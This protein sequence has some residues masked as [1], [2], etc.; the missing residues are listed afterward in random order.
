MSDELLRQRA[1]WNRE[2]ALFDAIYSHKKGRFGQWLDRTFRKDMYERYEYTLRHAEPVKNRDFLDVG[3]GTGRYIFDLAGRGCH[4]ATGIDISEQMIDHCRRAAAEAHLA[5][6]TEFVRT[7]L[8][9]FS[10]G[11]RYDVCIGVGL[12]DYIRDPLPVLKKMFAAAGDCAI[13]SFPRLCTWRAPVRK[14]RLLLRGCY[15]RFYTRRRIGSLLA[16][17]GF[18][19]YS[20]EKVGKLYCVTARVK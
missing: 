1:Y 4:H 19:G 14:I 2:I 6:R 16:A 11:R 5:D 13:L 7:D 20:L 8:L 3:C 10:P 15:V 18:K 12:F 17:A 9:D